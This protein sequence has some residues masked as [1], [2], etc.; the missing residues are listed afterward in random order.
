[1]NKHLS[2]QIFSIIQR[3][4]DAESK[5]FEKYT[6][7]KRPV[8]DGK[9][10]YYQLYE[11]YRKQ[12]DNPELDENIISKGAEKFTENYNDL[13]KKLKKELLN[14]LGLYYRENGTDTLE[15]EISDHIDV[16]IALYNKRLYL[17]SMDSFSLALEL[18]QRITDQ[19]FSEKILYLIIKTYSWLFQLRFC[20]NKEKLKDLSKFE[21][22]EDF[23]EYAR[24][25]AQ[26]ARSVKDA[27]DFNKSKNLSEDQFSQFSF[28]GLLKIY[29][30]EKG[31]F[32]N[33][34]LKESNYFP[35]IDPLNSLTNRTNSNDAKA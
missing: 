26:I 11:F 5:S 2:E 15:K 20:I 35:F 28:F 22:M 27:F 24:S 30:R 31:E 6:Q 14:F 3:M 23:L 18:I 12:K 7:R 10:A 4:D 16:G 1:M 34:N 32:E 13:S 33:L 21:E 17:L 29:L 19:Q 25:F 9:H 8:K